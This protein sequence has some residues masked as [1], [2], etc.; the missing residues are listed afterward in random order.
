MNLDE[1]F[2]RLA[3]EVCES[4]RLGIHTVHFRYR[5]SEKKREGTG[6]YTSD[7][8]NYRITV[9]LG[10]DVLDNINTMLHEL[11]H[12]ILDVKYGD[13]G[14][15]NPFW[16]TFFKLINQYEVRMPGLRNAEIAYHGFDNG[17]WLQAAYSL[18]WDVQF[19]INHINAEVER[20]NQRLLAARTRAQHHRT[21][22][23]L[24]DMFGDK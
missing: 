1:L 23:N 21:A 22:R 13:S 15:G 6:T 5:V 3:S 24:T 18:G 11:T 2:Q 17:K 16:Y 19:I 4:C 14:H 12:H 9:T 10:N 20:Y 8:A 7:G